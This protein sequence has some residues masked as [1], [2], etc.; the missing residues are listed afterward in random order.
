MSAAALGHPVRID[1][2]LFQ[3]WADFRC[4]PTRMH[5]TRRWQTFIRALNPKVAMQRIRT[6]ASPDTT[7]YGSRAWI[8][9]ACC[10]HM[11]MVWT[12]EGNEA[13]RQRRRAC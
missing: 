13:R 10:S 9:P 2:P 5:T 7:R 3:E 1:D 4:Q 11:D 6:P 8:I 12:E